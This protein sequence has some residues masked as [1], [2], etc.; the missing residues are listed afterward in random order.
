MGLSTLASGGVGAITTAE[1][2]VAV[3]SPRLRLR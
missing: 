2:P 3:S 1:I